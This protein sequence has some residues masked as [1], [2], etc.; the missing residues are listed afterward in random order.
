MEK[1]NIP[2]TSKLTNPNKAVIFTLLIVIASIFF[3]VKLIFGGN[4]NATIGNYTKEDLPE[5]FEY[6]I[7]K[8]EKQS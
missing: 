8:D 3:L 1:Q 7:T 2:N 5:N 4:S 6:R